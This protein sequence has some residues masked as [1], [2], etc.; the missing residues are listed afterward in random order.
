MT[1]AKRTQDMVR[2][3]MDLG[4]VLTRMCVVDAEAIEAAL[5]VQAN[6]KQRLGEILIDMGAL[7]ADQLTEAL[8]LQERLRA[9]GSNVEA[10][11]DLLE[12][13]RAN[14][15]ERMKRITA[16]TAGG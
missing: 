12:T 4:T 13:A 5:S 14:V 16:T 15:L 1:K 11:A 6:T 8:A 9:A 10:M 2:E 7:N 3:I